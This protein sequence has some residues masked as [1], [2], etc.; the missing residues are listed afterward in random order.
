MLLQD[1]TCN[2]QSGE[3]DWMPGE[4]WNTAIKI[5][6]YPSPEQAELMEKTFG[7]CR[8]LW[9]H[10]L[11]DVQELRTCILSLLQPITRRKRR[12]CVKSTVSRCVRSIRTCGVRFWTSF[13][14]PGRSN[15]R[16]SKR[17]SPE[18]IPSLFIAGSTARDHPS[19]FWGMAFRCRNWVS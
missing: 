6:L 10:I 19:G 14:I 18:K 4:K 9:N 5:R 17:K 11:A 16:S 12:F 1:T 15:T 13:A 3:V 7:C 2:R 8:W